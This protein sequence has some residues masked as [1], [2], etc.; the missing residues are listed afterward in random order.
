[1]LFNAFNTTEMRQVH[2]GIRP[3]FPIYEVYSVRSDFAPRKGVEDRGEAIGG[4]GPHLRAELQNPIAS[5]GHK[6]TIDDV[7]KLTAKAARL[8]DVNY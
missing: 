8:V 4:I 6:E 1:M 2:S 5:V 3:T 7:M